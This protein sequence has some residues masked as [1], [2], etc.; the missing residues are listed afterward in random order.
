MTRY[1]PG[2][3]SREI[4]ESKE[5]IAMQLLARGLTVTQISQQLRCSPFFV[6]KC[7]AKLGSRSPAAWG[8]RS[9]SATPR[10]K[11]GTDFVQ[12]GTVCTQPPGG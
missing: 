7:R 9:A 5:R 12:R 11:S 1:A 6:R 3:Q 2:S 4:M 10:C 8:S